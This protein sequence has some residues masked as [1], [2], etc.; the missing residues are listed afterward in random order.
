M[1]TLLTTK[2]NFPP[3]RPNL[4][5]RPR[6]LERLSQGL[7][8]PLTLVAAPAG[9]GK[10]TLMGEWRAGQGHGMLAAY[11]SLE[12]SDNDP[13]RFWFYLVSALDTV[14]AD[15]VGD[16]L[17]L[18]ASAQPPAVDALLTLLINN[19][20]EFQNNIVLVLDDVHVITSSE[21]YQGIDFL[22][23]H[24]P[25]HMHLVMLT[26]ADPP[27]SL[28]R[29]RARG[30]LTE[31]RAEH[32]RFNPEETARFLNQI[33]GFS[34]TPGQISALEKHTEGWVAGL[35]LAAL[36]MQ[37][38]QDVDGFI[39]AFTG[40]HHYIVD[41]LAE[42]VLSR[43]PSSVSEFLLKTSILERLTGALCDAL[44]RRT[45]GQSMLE[46][47]VQSNLF[48]LPLDDERRWYRYHDL[49]RDVLQNRL[50]C[51]FADDFTQ[52]HRQAAEWHEK[53]DLTRAALDHA[54]SAQDFALAEQLFYKYWMEWI[55]LY[56]LPA[57]IK[58]L[59]QIPGAI[60]RAAPRLSL[61][62]GW[63]MWAM[64]KVVDTESQ[65]NITQKMI[66]ELLQT[67][68]FH[69]D[70]PEYQSLTAET[71]IL[72]SLVATHKRAYSQA[73][74]LAESAIQA[75][76]KDDLI[77]LAAA[78]F[79]LSFACQEMGEVDRLLQVSIETLSVAQR[80]GN[81]S[82]CANAF[83][84]LAYSYKM[85]GRLHAA[86]E[87][88]QQAL[89]YAREHEQVSEPPY[90]IIY[91]S[92]A[93]LFYEWN[94]LA[95]A[96]QYLS[97]GMKM[98]EEAG[99]FVNLLW[100]RPLSAKIKRARGDLQGALNEM[101]Q[102]VSMARRDKLTLFTSQSEAYYARLQCEVGRLPDAL[103]WTN[104]LELARDDRL[105]YERSIDAIQCAYILTR[106]D[107]H[108]EALDLLEWV[109][110]ASRA[111]N[112][113]NSLLEAFILQAL[114]WH[115]RGD[116]LQAE[117][118]LKNA[119]SLAEPEGYIRIFLDF[120][121]PLRGLL[122]KATSSLNDMALLSYARKLLAAF[123]DEPGLPQLKEKAIITP[124]SER[125][126]D[127]LRLI[128]AG[129]SN[130]DI[131]RELVIALGTVKRHVFN[132]YNKLDVKN[133]TECVARARALHLLE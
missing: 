109:E 61:I 34:L 48:L 132:I 83:R 37:G 106:L 104:S 7:R 17:A 92:I 46:Y 72:R 98:I 78:Y 130:Q 69:K 73:I 62:N 42:E 38:R 32:L 11:L 128:A 18:L 58:S 111:S 10:T 133:R 14:Q 95:N 28:S 55:G 75:I 76:S 125:E 64:G 3:A 27:L 74:Q 129:K 120:G 71:N 1:I 50:Q 13:G 110:A 49:F 44:T 113:M 20:N 60:I 67:G 2:L 117:N 89:E 80:S 88:Y 105:G 77:T 59:R 107:R 21:I 103:T 127:V 114:V 119:M 66:D 108:N 24:V 43:L 85:Q 96:E 65:I 26:R 30:Q 93:E 12:R 47:L 102:V 5:P 100:A 25:P 118:R 16:T 35:Q 84:Y 40:S 86:F 56:N 39:S 87:T 81:S 57:N 112:N 51:N 82:V 121:E 45:D 79:A 36:S 53:N 22:L 70:S 41:Y 90:N 126:F 29:L 97:Q 63:M 99:F 52:L 131:A 91:N 31:I 19:I 116:F 101:H 33:I 122:T 4:V 124:L 68:E 115:H 6:L 123:A 23:E 8:G 9:Y 54:L 94:D 15:L